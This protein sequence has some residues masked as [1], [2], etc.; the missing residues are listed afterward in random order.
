MKYAV[1][2]TPG[3]IIPRDPKLTIRMQRAQPDAETITT[4][5]PAPV[6]STML[7]AN[8]SGT[9]TLNGYTC[10]TGQTFAMYDGDGALADYALDGSGQLLSVDHG[11]TW[12]FV[13][14]AVSP[15]QHVYACEAPAQ[16]ISG[17]G[18]TNV[19]LAAIKTA[20]NTYLVQLDLDCDFA[21][22]F[23]AGCYV[24]TDNYADDLYSELIP[25][26]LTVG[27]RYVLGFSV[28]DAGTVFTVNN[29]A[30][31]STPL[32]PDVLPT[33]FGFVNGQTGGLSVQTLDY[34]KF[35]GVA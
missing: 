15:S 9:G 16:I 20:T 11:V 27:E 25:V 18:N 33:L 10:D 23:T 22:N 31:G 21:G 24:A 7:L 13:S 35:A 1:T 19:R 6:V 32:K 34:V 26:A 29:V 12:A 17:P 28:S 2:L 5:L 3:G 8:F 14:A 30:I 4:Q